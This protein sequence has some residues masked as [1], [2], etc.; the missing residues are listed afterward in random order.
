MGFRKTLECFHLP[1]VSCKAFVM[2]R[3]SKEAAATKDNKI[4]VKQHRY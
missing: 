1:V 3:D 4:T 2:Q